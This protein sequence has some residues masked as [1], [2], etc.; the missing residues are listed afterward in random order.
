MIRPTA[1]L[2]EQVRAVG[3][4]GCHDL[5]QAGQIRAMCPYPAVAFSFYAYF[6]SFHF[7]KTRL[8]AP[9]PG[10]SHETTPARRHM[11]PV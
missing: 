9:S 7:C 5:Q 3:G 1:P 2:V 4:S 10:S 11:A 6:I 8:K